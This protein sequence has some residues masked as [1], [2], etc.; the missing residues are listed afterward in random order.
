MSLE[1]TPRRRKLFLVAGEASGDLYGGQLV[2]ALLQL[3][4]H[5]EIRGW[6]GEA[7]EASGVK[8]ST[9]YR[10]LA[11]MGF[12]EVLKNLKTIRRNLKRCTEEILSFPA[13]CLCG[14]R[15]S[16]IQFTGC[17]QCRKSRCFYPPLHLSFDL[18]L[19]CAANP[20]ASNAPFS[21]CM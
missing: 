12:W 13:R 18:G 21:A 15:F 4:P 17:C 8:I 16:R 11:F 9:H 6:G 1:R 14:Y 3:D 10:E 20:P 5:L 7:M 2:E 19:E